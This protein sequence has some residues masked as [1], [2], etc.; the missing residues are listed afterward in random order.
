MVSL[1]LFSRQQTRLF[2]VCGGNEDVSD[3]INFMWGLFVCSDK[4]ELLPEPDE[5]T[6]VE[7]LSVPDNPK[8]DKAWGDPDPPET[9]EG[10]VWNS[11]SELIDNDVLPAINIDSMQR[12][13][14]SQDQHAIQC[15]G[16]CF[17][18]DRVSH[19]HHHHH[20]HP[21]CG[22][23]ETICYSFKLT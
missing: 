13:A 19:H 9:T 11:T 20:P 10:S 12:Y 22:L 14:W 7:S 17:N 8:P 15:C 18:Y 16:V 21:L 4:E 3:V 5:Q 6:S 1:F 23:K 2:F